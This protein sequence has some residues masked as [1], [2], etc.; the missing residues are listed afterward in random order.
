L[1]VTVVST[2]TTQGSIVRS[3]STVIWNV[4]TLNVNAGASLVLTVQPH[5]VGSLLNTATASAGTPDPNPDDDF[6][7]AN[8][9]IGTLSATLTPTYAS[10]NHTFYISVPGP[11]NPS[12]TVVIQANTNLS[13]TNWMNIYTGTPP[14]NFSEPV[15]NTTVRRFYR[16]LLLP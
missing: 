7:S 13:G 9:D 10:S 15:S 2:N 8:V 1:G 12:V 11:T 3:G 14:I 5:G 4:G 16:A 6:A